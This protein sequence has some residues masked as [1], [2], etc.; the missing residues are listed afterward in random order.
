VSTRVGY[1]HDFIK[2]AQHRLAGTAL[3]PRFVRYIPVFTL[4]AIVLVG[5]I[6]LVRRGNWLMAFIVLGSIGL[7]WVTPWPGQ[8]TRYLMP[9]SPFL[10]VCAVVPLASAVE[11]SLSMRQRWIVFAQVFLACILVL[12]F[13][14]EGYALV[15]AFRQRN[16]KEAIVI[17]Q[18]TGKGYRLFYHDNSW[19]AWEQAADWVAAHARSD[20]IVATTA[21]H[22]FY[23]RTGHCA[24]L[25]PMETNP[26]RAQQLLERVPVSYVVVDQLEF[27]DL[28]RRYARPAIKNH[29]TSW[30]LVYSTHIRH[31]RPWWI[32]PADFVYGTQ[33]FQRVTG[34]R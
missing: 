9:L 5:L 18:T 17:P 20:A 15:K 23:L 2:D 33:V 21:P 1:W 24:V 32:K 28:T 22:F 31:R 8:F 25:P 16:K 12:A 3:I 14:A 19:Q 34:P 10:G 13:A 27:L 11:T 7:V 29:P 30:E 4:M 26:E 6:I